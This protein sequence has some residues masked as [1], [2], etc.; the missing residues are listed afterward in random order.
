M[1]FLSSFMFLKGT[2]YGE[3]EIEKI[4][5]INKSK[6]SVVFQ[7]SLENGEKVAIKCLSIKHYQKQIK[8]ESSI[9]EHFSN[10]ERLIKCLKMFQQGGYFCFVLQYAENG[11]LLDYINQRKSISESSIKK[12]I[13]DVLVAIE[14]LHSKKYCHQDIKLE[15]IFLL[16]QGTKAVLGDFG[17]TEILNEGEKSSSILGSLFYLSPEILIT[18][19]HDKSA[20]IWALGVTLFT[21]LIG[22]FPFV[23]RNVNQLIEDINGRKNQNQ[24]DSL[25]FPELDKVSKEAKDLIISMLQIDPEKRITPSQALKSSW[26]GYLEDYQTNK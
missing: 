26:F 3:Y 7:S 5:Y 24:K 17:S 6:T 10:N 21:L 14:D 22:E 20:D 2:R 4:I 9:F 16:N 15:N 19:K 1:N 11:D 23:G 12:I 18:K 13:F 25:F 8:N